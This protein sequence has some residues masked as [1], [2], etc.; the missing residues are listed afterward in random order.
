LANCGS[1]VV[2]WLSITSSSDVSLAMSAMGVFFWGTQLRARTAAA[3]SRS[4]RMPP[5]YAHRM[6]PDKR[7][8]S[9]LREVDR[10]LPD[11]GDV[12][13]PERPPLIFLDVARVPRH[14]RA[15]RVD[16]RDARV[17]G[18]ARA[19]QLAVL[20]DGERPAL[21]RAGDLE[22]RGALAIVG[23]EVLARHDE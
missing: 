15:V 19:R 17:R 16:R 5:P 22:E 23:A 8:P 13:D 20:G 21:E 18:V 1:N 9:E 6:R 10:A 2:A 4:F 14:E 3:A 12:E 7:A 11:V